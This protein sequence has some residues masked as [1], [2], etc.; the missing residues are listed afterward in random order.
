MRKIRECARASILWVFHCIVF[1]SKKEDV[2]PVQEVIMIPTLWYILTLYE[3]LTVSGS[4]CH[5]YYSLLD[6]ACPIPLLLWAS[7]MSNE[8][9]IQFHILEKITVG[10]FN[11]KYIKFYKVSVVLWESLINDE[12]GLSGP[13]IWTA[14]VIILQGPTL[15]QAQQKTS[16]E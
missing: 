15:T 10:N 8:I 7:I 4:Q 11:L 16:I 1:L 13:E 6:I 9:L 14:N 2:F 12:I 5:M 3:Y